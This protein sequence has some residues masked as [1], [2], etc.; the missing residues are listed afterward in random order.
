MQSLLVS[1]RPLQQRDPPR[2]VEVDLADAVYEVVKWARRELEGVETELVLEPLKAMGEPNVLNQILLNLTTNAALA[3]KQLPSPRLRFHVYTVS[4]RAVVSVRDNGPGIP[5]DLH[6][7]IFEPF[8]TTR[9]GQGG[10]GLGLALCRE[11]AR[12]IHGALT[13]WSQ[14]GRGACFRLFLRQP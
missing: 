11:Y 14:P 13:V 9:R 1:L 10:T 2:L 3:A 12:L 7:R 4:D 8:Y 5:E 6:T